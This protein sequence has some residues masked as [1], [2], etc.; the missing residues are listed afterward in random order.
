MTL[1]E[2]VYICHV[3]SAVR[4]KS[5]PNVKYWKNNQ[6]QIIDRVPEEDKNAT[7]WEEYDPREYDNCSLS[8]LND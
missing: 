5:N 4:R 2:A 1:E 7:D 3:R 6:I 8:M